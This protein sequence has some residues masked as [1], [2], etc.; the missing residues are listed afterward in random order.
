MTVLKI[1]TYALVSTWSLVSSHWE[2]V[3]RK[4]YPC[5]KYGHD[6]W[7][8]DCS[9]VFCRLMVWVSMKG[10]KGK[11]KEK[12]KL[13]VEYIQFRLKFLTLFY[14]NSTTFE[15]PDLL[16]VK[17]KY[18]TTVFEA[19]ILRQKICNFSTKMRK[20]FEVGLNQWKCTESQTVS[21]HM[22]LSMEMLMIMVKMF[23]FIV[24][25]TV[26]MTTTLKRLQWKMAR[27]R[28]LPIRKKAIMKL[29]K[30]VVAKRW[31]GSGWWSG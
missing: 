16:F 3:K 25:K 17:K 10:W 11:I 15:T 1:L 23:N 4:M 20:W 6:D 2:H 22:L 29:R 30:C 24:G 18:A 26:V 14:V 5:D 9:V 27:C 31:G 12:V 19:K 13:E 7:P 21:A 8:Y 28:Q